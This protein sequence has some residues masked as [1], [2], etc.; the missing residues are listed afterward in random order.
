MKF[1]D[2]NLHSALSAALA[3]RGY[4]TATAVQA[5][6]LDPGAAGRD[7]LVSSQTGSGKTIAFGVILVDTLLGATA[8]G[9]PAPE[10]TPA[11][12]GVAG[13][14]GAAGPAA[15]STP[16]ASPGGPGRAFV[17]G[18]KR[19]TALVIVPTRE[20]A[21]Q[22]R[23]EL[24][25]LLAGT[26]L[27]LGSFTGGTAV[28]GDLRVLHKGVDVVIGT[29]GRLVDLLSR[30]RLDLSG[31]RMVVLDEA[32]EMLDLGFR[33][34]L[35][36]LLGTAS[37][38]RR[39]L[40]LSATLPS[41]IRA[42][43]RKYQRDALAI[44]PRRSAGESP[45]TP[46]ADI[47]YVAHL[48]SPQDRLAT[49]V[50]VLRASGAKRA[51]TFCTT[52]D[53]VSS[54]HAA[55]MARGFTA[56]AISGERAQSDRDRALELIR[57]G[58]AQVLVATNVA[59]RGLHLPD[60]DLII[61]ADLPLNAE[62]LTHRSGRTGRAGRKGTAVVIATL[63]ERRKA[64]RLMA[65]AHVVAPWTPAPTP[66]S[67]TAA[68]RQRL[69]DEL[70]G[71]AAEGAGQELDADLDA[72]PDAKGEGAGGSPPAVA[73]AAA[74]RD[75]ALEAMLDRLEA[76]LE[77]REIVSRLLR[78]E[79]ERL[80]GGEP[81]HPVAMPDGREGR[82][83]EMD[84]RARTH[85]DGRS[86]V[87]F[88]INM[89]ARDKA[90][91]KWMLP[92]ICRR[93]NV[94]RRE[95][96][97]I[98]IGPVETIFEIAEEAALDFGSAAAE[99][100][101][102]APHVR[103]ERVAFASGAA[104]RTATAGRPPAAP[105]RFSSRAP[106]ARAAGQAE[107]AVPTRSVPSTFGAARPAAKAAPRPIS[108]G[109]SGGAPAP[110]TGAPP[111]APAPPGVGAG[112]VI[113]TPTRPVVPPT[114][115][116]A[117]KPKASGASDRGPELDVAQ[118]EAPAPAAAGAPTNG[119]THAPKTRRTT[120][121]PVIERKHAPP[122]R[123]VTGAPATFRSKGPAGPPTARP[124]RPPPA[125]TP[126]APPRADRAGAP[127]AR[128]APP[129]GQQQGGFGPPRRFTPQPVAG[130][131]GHVGGARRNGP[132][133][134]QDPREPDGQAPRGPH[135]HTA[136][137]ARAP[138]DGRARGGGSGG[139]FG[140]RSPPFRP[141]GPRPAPA[142]SGNRDFA[143]GKS[144]AGGFEAGAFKKAAPHPSF[145]KPGK[146]GRTSAAATG[147]GAG[148]PKAKAPYRRK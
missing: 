122:P 123:G 81:I 37:P 52:R 135:P 8:P 114:A 94:T 65:L 136:P 83:R 113:P 50:N 3:A 11:E 105:A 19:P 38:D 61:H 47:N 100:D 41:E 104:P 101:P 75:P 73:V 77:S 121:A 10:P 24:G 70:L 144:E 133:S 53:A 134:G 90:D 99:T 44:D 82:G 126:T 9:A 146:P 143:R 57:S 128:V 106:A 49:V 63:A 34:D 7:L 120:T 21:V 2:L 29:P 74:P 148:R 139:A 96:G 142:A 145:R 130:W 71:T 59:A 30:E 85:H 48:I 15:A 23:D 5:A 86:G 20:L 116:M 108:P 56:T 46:H 17:F 93:G 58:R 26:R 102:R 39:T 45:A 42:L 115:T 98:R 141:G 97:A 14:S 62:S 111:V 107:S 79:L 55:L 147:G 22:V 118:A 137:R 16:A 13:G 6:V 32:D 92:L 110:A 40:L 132:A 67:I 124:G 51:I 84:A 131:G 91:P 69:L 25:W 140:K 1:S 88:R 54:L 95:V 80:P 64:E 119:V 109:V 18:G 112:V 12:D 66:D 138:E 89:G 125:S 4:E 72:E 43:A 31:L 28:S 127:A 87:L 129:N 36:T 33:E 78:R 103:V 60:V 117:P 68:A 27:R 76:S 35:E